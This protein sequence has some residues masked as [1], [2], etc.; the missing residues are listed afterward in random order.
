M[1]DNNNA[2]PPTIATPG[3][4]AALTVGF[5]G[6]IVV[7]VLAWVL[8]LPAIDASAATTLPILIVALVATNVLTLRAHPSVGRVKAGLLGGLVTGLVNL[9]IVGSVAVEQPES[10][11]AMAEYANQF[12]SE[13]V[14]IIPGTILLCVIAGGIGA[15]LARGGRARLTSRSAWLARL[16]LVTVFVYLP[17]IAVG[18]AVT[19]TESGLAVP[20]AVTSY[21]AVSVL[22]PFELMSEPR[23][24][25]EHSHRLFGTLA[26]LA[27][28]VLM[29]SVLLFEPRKYCKLLALLLF[30][31]VCVQGYMGIK[32]VSELSTPIAIL[33]GV[34]GQIVFTLAGLL[35]AG[36]SLPWTQLPPDEERAAAAAKARKWGW[37][38]VG[39][40]FLQLAMGAAARHLDRMD[41]PSPGAS[42]ARLTHAA[43]AFV[44][45]FVIVLAG[46]FAIRVGKA[47]AGFKGIRRLGA[48]LHGIVTVQFLLGWAA[49]GLI[50]T[51]KEPLEVPTADRLAA[52]API[53][54]LEALVTTTHQATGAILLLLAVVTAAWL[55][56]LARPRKP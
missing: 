32:R 5:A 50:M 1:T 35:A 36:L 24:F 4:L 2:H 7:W 22:F 6:V 25:L 29:V 14:L 17:L 27:T 26:G 9:L 20:D 42:H 38:M 51:R 10:T 49:L 47:G 44:V 15:L 19:S 28:I 11:D 3:A 34:F 46:A 41:P 37:L 23:I 43:F 31:A 13:A 12:R 55:S 48:G 8:H 53:R 54:T 33:H 39:F 21:G 40:L 30:V 45:M 52:A 56:R 18:G 16:G